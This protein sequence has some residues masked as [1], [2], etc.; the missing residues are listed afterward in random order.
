MTVLPVLNAVLQ[1]SG[2]HEAIMSK[3]PLNMTDIH[4]EYGYWTT[5]ALG[6]DWRELDGFA[7]QQRQ[8]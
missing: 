6:W 4:I 7:Q 2:V 8:P 3:D 5:K 1:R